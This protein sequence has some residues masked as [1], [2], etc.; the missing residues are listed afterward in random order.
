MPSLRRQFGF[1]G[2]PIGFGAI[3]RGPPPMRPSPLPPQSQILTKD[4]GY[5]PGVCPTHVNLITLVCNAEL[6]FQRI[7]KYGILNKNPNSVIRR[8]IGERFHLHDK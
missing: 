5:S 6:L 1:G 7:V 3:Y 4:V 8:N 2:Y